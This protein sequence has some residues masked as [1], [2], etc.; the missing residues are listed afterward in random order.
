MQAGLCNARQDFDDD[1]VIERNQA[2]VSESPPHKRSM[3]PIGTPQSSE[4]L[5]I[6]DSGNI[7]RE[8]SI[9]RRNN[10]VEPHFYVE[11][12]AAPK[13][14]QGIKDLHELQ[15]KEKQITP[16]SAEVE[17]ARTSSLV[18]EDS[19]FME[20]P[21][22]AGVFKKLTPIRTKTESGGPATNEKLRVTR[23]RT[24]SATPPPKAK[25]QKPSQR[26]S[27]RFGNGEFVPPP[28]TPERQESRQS[29]Q[30]SEH[31][32]SGNK[33]A[34]RSLFDDSRKIMHLSDKSVGYR[35]ANEF[36]PQHGEVRENPSA[37][38]ETEHWNHFVS[39]RPGNGRSRSLDKKKWEDFSRPSVVENDEHPIA[40]RQGRTRNA[41]PDFKS[42][43]KQSSFGSQYSEVGQRRAR[44]KDARNIA[45]S[46][47]RARGSA[48]EASGSYDED[49]E[50]ARFPS[51]STED[52]KQ[53]AMEHMQV[54][55]VASNIG[56]Q[57]NESGWVRSD[58]DADFDPYYETNVHG[59]R[60]NRTTR[61][62]DTYSQKAIDQWHRD[63]VLNGLRPWT[64][65]S[66]MPF[67]LDLTGLN[68]RKVRM[69]IDKGRDR[70]SQ[71]VRM[72][73]VS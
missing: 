27:Q 13:Q 8:G 31:G 72:T 58:F 2:M 3:Q 5:A 42:G 23:Q 67:H 6:R 65:V 60:A 68:P 44:Q 33:S 48:S 16:L 40:T 56:S 73:L 63:H 25:L 20:Q 29:G 7:S 47:P 70:S 69:A 61:R 30:S 4:R 49:F 38:A 54:N 24:P 43:P 66:T 15:E 28:V 64:R 17:L 14:L 22:L 62:P 50:L 57:D 39:R 11:I 37:E 34:R 18:D 32:S 53:A 19:A 36:I 51:L 41:R 9:S 10:E 59:T 21:Y 45:Y 71:G 35:R 1:S 12:E 26:S 52:W 46:E 55:R